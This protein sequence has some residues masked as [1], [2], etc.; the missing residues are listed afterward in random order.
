[1]SDQIPSIPELER[2]S[3]KPFLDAKLFKKG[4]ESKMDQLVPVAAVGSLA[5]ARSSS[6]LRNTLIVLGIIMVLAGYGV[7]GYIIYKRI[8]AIEN[9]IQKVI[10][11]S[12]K[13]TA[14]D[15]PQLQEQ[16]SKDEERK[17]TFSIPDDSED[18]DTVIVDDEDTSPNS[19]NATTLGLTESGPEVDQKPKRGGRRG[20]K[21]S[22]PSLSLDSV[23][24]PQD[25]NE[26]LTPSLDL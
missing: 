1:M 5:A 13:N 2:S 3:N 17:V 15:I 4:K 6:S 9:E 20:R 24:V 18:S 10:E 11:N 7:A 12:S 22:T 8:T 25:G 21:P 23:P 14:Q 19:D 16:E 26:T